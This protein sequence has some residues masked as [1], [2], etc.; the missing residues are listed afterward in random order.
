[1]IKVIIVALLFQKY[2]KSLKI[3]GTLSV[4]VPSAMFSEAKHSKVAEM[5]SLNTNDL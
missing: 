4:Q 2:F 5:K 3:S 1:M